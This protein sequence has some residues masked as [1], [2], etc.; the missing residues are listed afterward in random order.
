M[1]QLVVRNLDDDVKAKLQ[2]RAR[3]HGRSTEAEVR[4]ILANAVRDEDS[5]QLPL[6]SRIAAI[7]AGIGLD[8]DI[9]EL[10]GHPAKPAD[11]DS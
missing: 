4:D 9:P 1:A 3:R 7:F 6:G 11:F 2:L 8:E 5:S 10:R